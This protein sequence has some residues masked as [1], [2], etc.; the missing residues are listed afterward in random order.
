MEWLKFK[1]DTFDYHLAHPELD[2]SRYIQAKR[3]NLGNQIAG[4]HRIYMDTKQWIQMRDVALGKPRNQMHSDIYSQLHL[5]RSAGK[6][7]CPISYSVYVELMSQSDDVTRFA[8]A[9]VIDQLADGCCCLPPHVLTER[10]LMYFMIE[11][12]SGQKPN[13]PP[14]LSTVWT[15]ISFVLGETMPVSAA[16]PKETMGAIQRS[17]DDLLCQIT[18]EEMIRQLGS[19][20]WDA[21]AIDNKAFVEQLEEEK[22]R[23]SDDFTNFHE[24]FCIEVKGGL[25]VQQELLERVMI[26]YARLSGMT[27]EVSDAERHSGGKML[28]NLVLGAFS[29]KRILNELPQIHIHAALHAA[30]RWDKNRKYDLNDF[31][32]IRHAC[33]A[34]PYYHVFCTERGLCHQL[35][36][37]LLRL[38]EIYGTKVL[39]SDEEF[40]AHVNSLAAA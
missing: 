36:Q 31:E 32:D 37:K 18:V 2:T 16:F 6:V 27:G 33:V 22:R 4:C 23:H 19:R 30:L 10:E 35:R 25:E 38:D 26:E 24:L 7:I 11:K 5:L 9:R 40:L 20:D 13:V 12:G 21:R 34:L 29:Y 15:K 1:L 17:F 3:L 14:I 39:A 8:T 28:A